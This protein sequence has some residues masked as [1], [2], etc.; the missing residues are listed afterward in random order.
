MSRRGI[1]QDLGAVLIQAAVNHRS[2]LVVSTRHLPVPGSNHV[3]LKLLTSNNPLKEFRVESR[4]EALCAL[5]KLTGQVFR[6]SDILKSRFDE[7][8]S[9]ISSHLEK[10]SKVLHGVDCSS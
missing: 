9:C 4:N 2:A 8:N 1:S 3:L 7:P 6:E 10:H 5:G